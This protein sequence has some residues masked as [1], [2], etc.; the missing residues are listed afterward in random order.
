MGLDLV[1]YVIA[2]EEAFEIAIPDADARRLETPNKLIDYLCARLG[3][4]EDGP[5]LVQTGFYRLRNAIIEELGATRSSVKPTTK[6][7]ELTERSESE[8]WVAVARRLQV[9]RNVLTHSPV[10]GWLAKLVRAPGRS[11]GDVAR[12]VAM[13]KPV[14]LKPK[15]STWTRAQI[16][17][18]ATRLLE[19][20]TALI[21]NSSQLDERF[22]QDLGMG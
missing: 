6:L 19:H 7:G 12:D 1:E 22:I 11:V 9:K 3:E 2:I 18:V 15:N 10:V 4:S 5:P 17:E 13:L 14:A 8:V 20:E 16:T 21:I